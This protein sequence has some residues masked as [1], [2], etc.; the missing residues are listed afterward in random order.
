MAGRLSDGIRIDAGGSPE[1]IPPE[2]EIEVEV[3]AEVEVEKTSVREDADGGPEPDP[4]ILLNRKAT[5][6]SLHE[7]FCGQRG[8]RA[9]KLTRDRAAKYSARLESYSP[10]EIVTA[11]GNALA[12]PWLRGENDRG[13]DFG[14]PETVLKN[15]GAVDRWLNKPRGS[16]NGNHVLLRR[17]ESALRTLED[18]DSRRGDTG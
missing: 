2:V 16:P 15:D 14:Y 3:E 11:I 10:G 17:A 12:D 5:I 6:R 8:G 9:L 1:S 4:D 13:T 7:Y 18:F